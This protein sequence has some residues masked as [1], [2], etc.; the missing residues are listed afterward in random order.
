MKI[1]VLTMFPELFDSFL[2]SPVVKRAVD[3]GVLEIEITDIRD[4]AEGSFRHLDDSPCGGGAGMIM[5]C[6]V[7][8]PA[9]RSV[10]TDV[11]HTVILA[12]AGNTYNQKK[13]EEYSQLEHL[14][15]VC[16]HYEGMDARIYEEADE[17]LSIGDYVLTGGEPASEIIIDSVARL[18]KGAIRSSSIEEESFTNGLLEYPQYTRPVSYEGKDVPEVLLSGNHEKIRKW[19]LKESLRVTKDVRP[20]LLEKRELTK[21]EK[22]LLEEIEE[23]TYD[24]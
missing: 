4:F 7:V 20:D 15:L 8:I 1:S 16:G 3:K 11:S 21:E 6:D 5:R 14:I 13:A 22:K 9:I 17:L 19:R 24:S 12:P 18:L 23:E 2:L 10:K